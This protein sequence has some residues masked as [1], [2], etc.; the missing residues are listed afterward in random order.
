M[1][2]NTAL[3]AIVNMK[4]RHNLRDK[5]D[6]A[7]IQRMWDN[8]V[9]ETDALYNIKTKIADWQSQK[10]AIELPAKVLVTAAVGLA[11]A[12][13]IPAMAA[14]WGGLEAISEATSASSTKSAIAPYVT[15]QSP[16]QMEAYMG[17]SGK[18]QASIGRGIKEGMTFYQMANLG[19]TL[20]DKFWYKGAVEKA[21]EDT[22]TGESIKEAQ[23]YTVST[24]ASE[25][26]S[27]DVLKE[28]LA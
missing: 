11:T 22:I 23:S 9:S 2:R 28:A 27:E 4:K 10:E 17:V 21:G 7:R 26:G 14:T 13:N 24:A 15:K 16:K 18:E 5:I 1:S 20:A 19:S 25:K 3:S 6:M 8:V 12:G